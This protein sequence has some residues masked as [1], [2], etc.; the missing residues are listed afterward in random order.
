MRHKQG[1]ARP[2]AA[3]IVLTGSEE[4]RRQRQWP[5]FLQA[6]FFGALLTVPA[7]GDGPSSPSG[8]VPIIRDFGTKI[9]YGTSRLLDVEELGA[10]CDELRG[11]F[12]ECG[13]VC[14]PVPG[15]CI[16]VCAFTC[17]NIPR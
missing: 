5:F 12:N 10:H 8:E 9:V 7:C 16:T 1:A 13:S 4:S 3:A 2:A 11:T 15:P 17:E 6:A 14:A